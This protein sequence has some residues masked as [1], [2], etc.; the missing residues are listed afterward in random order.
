M[1][2]ITGFLVGI[3]LPILIAE[4]TELS[5]EQ[6]L[7]AELFKMKIQLSQCQLTSEQLN[8]LNEFKA[9][10]G[11]KSEFDWNTLTFK[12]ASK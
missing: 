12:E 6:K 10:T 1:K 8:L 5:N 7:K 3:S 9:A 11:N 2:F 4:G